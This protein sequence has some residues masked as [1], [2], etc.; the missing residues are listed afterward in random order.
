M[1]VFIPSKGRPNTNTHKM[2]EEA[3]IEVY[4]FIEP[5]ELDLYKV[6]NKISIEKNNQGIGYVR[7]FMLQYAKAKNLGWV[8]ISDDDINQFGVYENGIKNKKG[9]SIWFDILKKVEKLPFE[10]VGINYLQY[11]WSQKKDY[12]INKSFV[13]V[14]ILV[15]TKNIN[16][17]YRT[18]FNLKEDRDFALQAIKYGNGILKFNKYYYNCPN[19]G[20]NKGGLQD[21][22]KMKADEEAARKMCIEWNPNIE[23]KVNNGRIDIKADIESI[24]LKYKKIVK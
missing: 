8:I 13:E 4:H 12:S 9:A 15:N 24:A 2:F 18:Q 7:N 17:N 16:W 11:A 14:C 21:Q 3:G 23:L 5:Q 6:K 1:K 10:I 19:V 22:Y 20:K